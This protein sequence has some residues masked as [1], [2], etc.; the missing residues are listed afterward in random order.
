[1][2]REV[3]AGFFSN[4]AGLYPWMLST[5]PLDRYDVYLVTPRSGGE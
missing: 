2:A 4:G 5:Q 1:M 3:G